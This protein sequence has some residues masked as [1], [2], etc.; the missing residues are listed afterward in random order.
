MEEWRRRKKKLIDWEEEDE[1]ISE[2]EDGMD[3]CEEEEDETDDRMSECE[4]EV[5]ENI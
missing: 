2:L 4:V 5:Y 1:N 3:Y